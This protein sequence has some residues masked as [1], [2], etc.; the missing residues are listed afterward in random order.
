MFLS[1]AMV[2]LTT[3]TLNPYN[4]VAKVTI[5]EKNS[6]VLGFS[7]PSLSFLLRNLKIVFP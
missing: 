5:I 7:Y 3:I 6:A 4:E 1:S 2:S